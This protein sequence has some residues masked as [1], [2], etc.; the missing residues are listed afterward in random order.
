M[1]NRKRLPAVFYKLDSKD[2][3]HSEGSTESCTEWKDCCGQSEQKFAGH[4]EAKL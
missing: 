3:K 4:Y 2:G 1:I